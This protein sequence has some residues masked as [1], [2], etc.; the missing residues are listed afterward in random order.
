MMVDVRWL[1]CAGVIAVV[2]MG[3]NAQASPSAAEQEDQQAERGGG[4][5]LDLDALLG[6]EDE[7]GS[8]EEDGDEGVVDPAAGLLERELTA[9]EARDN[10]LQAIRQMGETADRLERLG[11]TGLT[12]Q[13]LQRDIIAKLD[14]LIEFAEGQEGGGGGSGSSSRQQQQQQGEPNRPS[15]QQGQQT[16]QGQEQGQ[17]GSESG[18]GTPPGFQE[19]EGS[20]FSTDSAAWGALPE[21]FREAL[22]EGA[23]DPFSPLY[24]AA[25]E[26]YYR[27][28]AEEATGR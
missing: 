6:L 14:I 13:R 18:E 9:T 8:E 17:G 26:A 25:T 10:L 11:D 12:T 19:G 2:A 27:R 3:V 20:P 4:D 21:R 24:R 7:E 16:G 1:L 5:P 22:L 15:Q 23:G 28:I